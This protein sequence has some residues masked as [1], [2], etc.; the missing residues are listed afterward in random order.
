MQCNLPDYTIRLWTN[1]NLLLAM[2]HVL[3][4]TRNLV[5]HEEAYLAA[6]SHLKLVLETHVPR[7]G[8]KKKAD[9]SAVFGHWIKRGQSRFTNRHSFLVMLREEDVAETLK[10]FL[11]TNR[12]TPGI[13]LTFKY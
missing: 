8:S 2:V 10:G 5:L 6:S 3:M 4:H 13:I 7:Q 11:A 12:R 9:A 1:S